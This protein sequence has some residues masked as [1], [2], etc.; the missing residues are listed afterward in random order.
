[1][2]PGLLNTYSECFVEVKGCVMSPGLYNIYMGGV[3]E[4]NVRLF[5]AGE[6]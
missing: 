4:V 2:P 3:V 1:M 5:A 6:C